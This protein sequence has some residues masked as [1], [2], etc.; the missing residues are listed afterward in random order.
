MDLRQLDVLAAI[1]QSGS[2]TAAADSLGTVQSNVSAQIQALEKELH[3]TLIV[4]SRQG[5]RLTEQGQVVVDRAKRI[6]AEIDSML[7]DLSMLQ[8]LKRGHASI[9]VIGTASRWI[10]PSLVQE[11]RDSAPGVTLHITEAPSERLLADVIT[12]DLSVAVITEPVADPRVEVTTLCDEE[13][14]GIAPKEFG[15]DS[16]PKTFAELSQYP[17]VLTPKTNPLRTWIDK[18]ARKEEVTLD[19]PVNCEGIRL[20][21]RLVR[22]GVGCSILPLTALP[23]EQSVFTVYKIENLPPRHLALISAKDAVLSMAERVVSDVIIRLTQ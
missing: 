4:R 15:L 17:H 5:A 14:V 13:I 23:N 11:M 18:A 3:T 6:T 1:H 20:L 8:G 22:S 12:H 10:V 7:V 21:P 16:S 2:F 9:G 19:V